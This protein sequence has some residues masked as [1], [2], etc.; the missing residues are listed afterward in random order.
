MQSRTILVVDDE[1]R[2]RNGL[3]RILESW[4]AGRYVIMTAADGREAMEM[5]RREPVRLLITDIRMPEIGGLDLAG[6]LDEASVKERPAVILVSGYA[7]FEYAQQAIQLGVTD[8][9]LKPIG[10]DKLIAAVERALEMAEE[11]TRFGMMQR[12]VD[13]ELLQAGER[14]QPVS[15][16]IKDAM[17]Y[18]D[19]NLAEP[20]TLRDV[21]GHAHLN[22]SYF[23][24]LFKEQVGLTFSEYV[25]RRRLQK[26]K[27]M[28]LQTKLP[29]AEIAERVG[30][31]SAK[32]FGKIFKQYEGGSP[33]QFRSG[34]ADDDMDDDHSEV[35]V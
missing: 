7:E 18:I 25:T 16:P 17:D 3:K 15:G 31:Q 30:Y 4:S 27:E 2:S 9:L 23:S 33:G 35:T 22:P 32:Y 21:A 34:E 26:A 24:V 20:F 8:Y 19:A 28:L 11:R 14:L 1:P 5:L 6:S 13:P 10:R 29:V 12:I